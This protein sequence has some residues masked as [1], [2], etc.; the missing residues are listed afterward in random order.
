MV[1]KVWYKNLLDNKPTAITSE[2]IERPDESYFLSD[3]PN[4]KKE[5]LIKWDQSAPYLEED[6]TI[7]NINKYNK[8]QEDLSKIDREVEAADKRPF[9]FNGNYYTPDTEFIQGMFS[10]L[11]ILPDN[12]TELWKTTDKEIDGVNN[13]YVVL[14]KSDI[15]GLALTYLQFK[16]N[17]WK[18]GDEKKKALKSAYIGV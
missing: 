6:I 14:D 15:Q 1:R 8:L 12:Y 3:I 17:N 18:I 10:I 11:S 13:V 9:L 16:K 2:K 5:Y 4:I 7:S